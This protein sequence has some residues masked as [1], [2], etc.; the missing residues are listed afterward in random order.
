MCTLLPHQSS[1][2]SD[3]AKVLTFTDTSSM[4]IVIHVP[5]ECF[6]CGPYH[7]AAAVVGAVGYVAL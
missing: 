7:G 2:M 4:S 6:D 5:L 3:H 1:W